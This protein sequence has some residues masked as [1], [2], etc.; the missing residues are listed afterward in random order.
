M[1]S[2]LQFVQRRKLA[3]CSYATQNND[4]KVFIVKV[5][6]K[7]MKKVDFYGNMF[8]SKTWILTDVGHHLVNS[9][10]QTRPAVVYALLKVLNGVL[11]MVCANIGSRAIEQSTSSF[12]AMNDRSFNSANWKLCDTTN[13]THKENKIMMPYSLCVLNVYRKLETKRI[14]KH[15]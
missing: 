3:L 6:R 2:S 1:D 4:L 11:D 8:V 14:T 12:K 9:S 10:M 5:L 7:L 15:D 13:H